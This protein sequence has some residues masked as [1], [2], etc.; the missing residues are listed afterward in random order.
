M[1]KRMIHTRV[2]WRDI[3]VHANI[4]EDPTKK[5]LPVKLKQLNL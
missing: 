5:R 1:F 3:N 2:A 4:Q